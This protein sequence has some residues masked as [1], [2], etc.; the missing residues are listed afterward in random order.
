MSFETLWAISRTP[1]PSFIRLQS[2]L[3]TPNEARAHLG[4]EPY[5]GGDTYYMPATLVPV[6][7]AQVQKAA[8]PPADWARLHSQ[9]EEALKKKVRDFFAYRRSAS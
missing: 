9:H 3:L 5:P 2:G 1:R 6:G 8:A 4:R 7:Q